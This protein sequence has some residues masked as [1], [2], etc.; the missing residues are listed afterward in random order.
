MRTKARRHRTQ[1]RVSPWIVV[2]GVVV[3]GL[4]AAFIVQGLRRH[5][6]DLELQARLAGAERSL[7]AP[8]WDPKWPPLWT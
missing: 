1:D 2:L 3:V 6:R 4:F 5:E 8:V 7:P